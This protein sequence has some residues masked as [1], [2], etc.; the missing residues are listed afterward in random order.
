MN[1]S[2][3]RQRG[4]SLASTMVGLTI[5]LIVATTAMSTASF[6]EAQKRV[7][8]G[9][10]SML[11]NG[12]LGLGRI[13]NEVRMAGLG[14]MSRHDFACTRMNIEY[15]DDVLLDGVALYPAAIVDGAGQP[16]SISVAYLDSITS[17]TYAPLL[18]AVQ[19]VDG[20]VNVAM[21]PDAKIGTVLLLQDTGGATPCTVRDVTA[22]G[23]SEFGA[24]LS[25]DNG[26]Y[27]G[28]KFKAPGDYPSGARVN[29]S[30]RF[31][32]TTFRIK[33]DTLEEVDN[34][35]GDAV[36]V[37]DGVV[38]MKAQYGVT[39]GASP[40]VSS[41]VD[42]FATPMPADMLRVRALRIGFIV[43]SMEKSTTCAGK[44]RLFHYWPDGPTLDVSGS[45]DWKCRSYRTFNVIVPLVNV[46]MGLK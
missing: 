38:G 20:A 17:A 18:M 3:Y 13:E 8:I 46:A 2:L 7:A 14:M 1:P 19:G 6:L 15:K 25:V 40:T 45:A 16:D 36:V 12:A 5:G 31:V 35:T 30:R 11:V 33:D 34:L 28:A 29:N 41:W 39:D 21:A 26:M 43:R 27:G 9:G 24:T 44:T 32:W 42:A 22:R 23:D 37:A 4:F 10:N